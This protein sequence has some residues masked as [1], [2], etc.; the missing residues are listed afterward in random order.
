MNAVGLIRDIKQYENRVM[1]TPEG[2]KE[3]VESNIKVF[4]EQGA[5]MDSGFTDIEYEKSGAIMLPTMEK[6][7]READLILQVHTP[8]PIQFELLN[9]S[10][11]F[12]SFASLI[13]T[14]EQFHSL[15]ETK[16]TFVCGSLFQ[17]NEGKYPV[18]MAMSEISGKMAIHE[19]A[20][21]LSVPGGG[22]GKLLD[23][24]E[25]VKPTVVTI[26]GAGKVGRTI[27]EQTCNLGAKVNLVSLKEEKLQ[28]YKDEFPKINCAVYSDKIIKEILPKTDLL[29]ISVFSLSQSYN[30][31]INKKLIKLME[32]GSVIIDISVD[33]VQVVEGSHPTNHDKPSYK[34]DG[35][36][37]YSVPNIASMIPMTS[38]RMLTKTIMPYLKILALKDLKKALVEE[39]GIIP[40]LGIYKGKVTNR[41]FADQFGYEFYN[42]FELLELNL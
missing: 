38:S 40:A 41:N 5:A 29:I 24:I 30:I 42:I 35:I 13:R 6:I 17:D 25:G 8:L 2:V 33:Q 23:H 3:L 28:H 20:R 14:G 10:H 37:Y 11:M 31:F 12:L 32:P 36:V 15:V 16:A 26:I 39:S 18:L 7:M 9:E 21:L 19:G 34:L 1:L 4:V 22:K 27:A